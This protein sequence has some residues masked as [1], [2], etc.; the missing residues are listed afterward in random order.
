MIALAATYGKDALPLYL[1]ERIL[2]M[3]IIFRNFITLSAHVRS[4]SFASIKSAYV[5][6]WMKE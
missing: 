4:K 2:F 3:E 1:I 5:F 6:S